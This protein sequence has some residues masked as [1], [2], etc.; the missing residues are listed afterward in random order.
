MTVV[1]VLDRAELGTPLG[2]MLAIASAG[3]VAFLEFTTS[4]RLSR[5]ARRLASWFGPHDIR[6]RRGPHVRA[7]AAWLGAYFAGE[8]VAGPALDLRGTPF[9]L[10]VWA[11]LLRIPAGTTSSYARVATGLGHP[12]K[13]RA[14]GA[15][16]GAN[17][18]TLIVPC[19]RLVGSSGGLTGYGG[20]LDSKRWLL[21]HESRWVTPG[22]VEHEAA[23]GTLEHGAHQSRTHPSHSIGGAGR[24]GRGGEP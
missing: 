23:M 5:V 24:F 4:D 3:G 11:H 16:N 12:N 22:R 8:L 10:A 1:H 14:V 9:E 7:T 13:A 19:H 17:P 15:A 21:Q 18:V 2:P 6:D 20:G